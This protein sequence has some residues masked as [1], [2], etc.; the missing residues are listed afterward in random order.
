M[1]QV[2]NN[3]TPAEAGKGRTRALLI[4]AGRYPNAKTNAPRRPTL[5]DLDSVG[6]SLWAFV[7]K[8]IGEWRNDLQAPLGTVD[9]LLSETAQPAGSTWRTL[10]I[11][12]EAVG[13]TKIDEPTLQNVTAA[14]TGCLQGAD[15]NDH[16][17][18]LC[19][20]HG[21]WKSHSF[22]ILSD[23]GS[24]IRDPWASVIDLDGFRLGLSQEKPRQQWL[25]FDCCKDI[26]AEILNN[27]SNIGTPMIQTDAEEMAR[28]NRLG[29]LSQFGM[30]SATPGQQ[31]FGIPGKPSRFCE[32]LLDALGGAGAISRKDGTWWVDDRGITDAVRSYARRNPDL[33]DPKFYTVPMPISSDMQDHMRFRSVSNEP[34]SQLVAFST[35][36]P[37]ITTA[38]I[39]VVRDGNPDPVWRRNPA[40]RAKLLIEL[41]ARVPCKIIATFNGGFAK[42]IAVFGALPLAEPEEAEFVL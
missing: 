10:G 11:Q 34:K 24:N 5:N 32:M 1:T 37:A 29:A 19:C 27:L 36:R 18:F 17:L 14:L 23:F 42:E 9:L 2:Y 30:N 39:S 25:F 40:G 28:A 13:G 20:G 38:D 41:P 26:P 3:P 15:V 21:F 22:F 35:P 4:G 7:T 6:P 16:F 33:S 31:A 8:L 12:G